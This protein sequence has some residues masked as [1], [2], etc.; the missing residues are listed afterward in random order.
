MSV[1]K[2]YVSLAT[3]LLVVS[4]S[5][6]ALEWDATYGNSPAPFKLAVHPE[7]IALAHQKVALTR[8]PIDVKQPDWSDGPPVHNATS[9]RDYWVKEYDWPSTQRDINSRFNMF[10]TTVDA[11]PFSEYEERVPLHFVHHRSNRSDAIP[12]LFIHGWPGS[13]LE[14]ENL[15]EPLTNPCDASLPAFHV[16]APSIPGFGFSPAPTKPLFGPRAAGEAFNNLMHQLNYTHYVIQGGDLGGFINRFMASSHPESV[17]SVLSNFWLVQPNSTDFARYYAGNTT[18]DETYV[19]EEFW[20]FENKSSGY[21]FEQQTS[22]LQIGYAMTD[23]PIGFAMYIY[24]FMFLTVQNYVWSAK[25]LITWS[26]MYWIQGPYAGFRFYKESVNDHILENGL[27]INSTTFPYIHQPVAISEF[28]ADIWYRTPLDWAQRGGNVVIRKVHE[29]GGHFASVE[30]PDLLIE[31][32]RSF[33]GNGTL[34]NTTMF[35]Y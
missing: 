5:T 25:E 7:I 33:F 31:D 30:T 29:E 13:F 23:S 22:P 34:S 10:T 32:I 24:E 18:D 12:L 1:I 17:L 35:G 16:V 14:V 9:V 19:I 11:K 28:P 21:R 20:N 8:Y 3:A 2:H 15:L 4:R 27:L 26:L 6:L